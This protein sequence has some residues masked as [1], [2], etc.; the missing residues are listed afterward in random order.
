M[1]LILKKLSYKDGGNSIKSVK[2][3]KINSILLN[4]LENAQVPSQPMLEISKTRY[5]I[6][7]L[8]YPLNLFYK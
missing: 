7:R 5:T 6:L 1:V 8:Y 4:F 3:S 2:R